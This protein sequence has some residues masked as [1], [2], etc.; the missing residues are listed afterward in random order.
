[1][2]HYLRFVSVAMLAMVLVGCRQQ[3]APTHRSST[4]S[5]VTQSSAQDP[6]ATVKTQG[7]TVEQVKQLHTYP[8]AVKATS[9]L[10][11]QGASGVAMQLLTFQNNED[12]QAAR[13]YYAGQDLRVYTSGNRL[14]TAARGMGRGWFEKY[15]HAIFKQ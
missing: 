15:Q 11:W 1:M 9:G 12:C 10:A 4:S 6:L 3:S 2:K 5:A 8:D 13:K 7:L 14:L